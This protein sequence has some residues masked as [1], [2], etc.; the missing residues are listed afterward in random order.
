MNQI[1]SKSL[2]KFIPKFYSKISYKI[3][4]LPS[5][6][7]LKVLLN[8]FL[9]RQVNFNVFYSKIKN[10][11]LSPESFLRLK[12]PLQAGLISSEDG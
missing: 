4:I 5:V 12:S 8:V 9:C 6:S 11:R 10:N 2:K 7:F 3:W 1:K